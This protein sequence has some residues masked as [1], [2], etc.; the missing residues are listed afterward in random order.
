MLKILKGG[1]IG[2]LLLFGLTGCQ[3]ELSNEELKGLKACYD[4]PTGIS[5]WSNNIL[6]VKK[7]FKGQVSM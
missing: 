7:I 2:T 1:A 4:K 6:Q 5:L 3:S